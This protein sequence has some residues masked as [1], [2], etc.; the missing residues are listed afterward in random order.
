MRPLRNAIA[1]DMNS[2]QNRARDEFRDVVEELAAVSAELCAEALDRAAY[3]LGRLV[4]HGFLDRSDAADAQ[5]QACVINGYSGEAGA[6][7]VQEAIVAGFSAGAAAASAEQ[8]AAANGADSADIHAAADVEWGKINRVHPAPTWRERV[9]TAA[10][11]QHK[12]FAPIT[13]VVAGLIPDG[14]SMLVG[15]P[16]IGKSWL[17]LDVALTVASTDGTCLGGLKVEHGNVLYC[18]CEDSDRRLQAR[19]TKLIGANKAAWPSDLQLTT[20]WERLDKGGVRDIAEWIKSVRRPR[21]AILDTLA[22]VKP[23]R[24][25]HGYHEDYA[26]LAELHR[27]ANNVGIAVLI[28]HHQR[29]IDAEDPLDTISGTL[30]LAGCVDT[31][32]ILA[33]TSQGKTLYVR[34]RDIEEAEHAVA[35]DKQG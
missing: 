12:T 25:T 30:G 15:R 1:I 2:A 3:E 5:T 23:Q 14:L 17:T 11:P 20:S 13:Y 4:E 28:L 16:K 32:I 24:T 29:K 22:S 19:I 6:D 8:T 31:P 9:F 35:F 21:L 27:L 7:A 26:A 34:G 18:A 10:S 33:G